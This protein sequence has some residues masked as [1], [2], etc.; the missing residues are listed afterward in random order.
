MFDHAIGAGVHGQLS[1]AAERADVSSGWSASVSRA[2]ESSGSVLPGSVRGT[3]ERSLGVDLSG[4]R[5]HTGDASARAA[6]AVSAKAYAVG[7]DIHFGSG[8][9]DPSSSSGKHLL[10]HEVA[11]TV[12][13]RGASPG[14][15]FKLEISTPGDA[16]EVEADRAADA[17]VRGAPASVRSAGTQL[18]RVVMRTP[19]SDLGHAADRGEIVER[20]ALVAAPPAIAGVTNVRDVAQAQRLYEEIDHD[21]PLLEQG[22][23]TG[24]DGVSDLVGAPNSL[25]TR[26]QITATERTRTALSTF[27]ASAGEQARELGDFQRQYQQCIIDFARIH[28]MMEQFQATH[29]EVGGAT[30]TT[31]ASVMGDS[32]VRAAGGRSVSEAA[33]RTRSI[34]SSRGGAAFG[35]SWNDFRA[36]RTEL[37]TVSREVTTCER[38]ASAQSHAVISAIDS[39]QAGPTTHEAGAAASGELAHVRAECERV[40]TWVRFATTAAASR[41]S[42]ALTAAEAPAAVTSA[43]GHAGAVSDFLVGAAYAQQIQTL[44]TAVARA[45]ARSDSHARDALMRSVR[46]A[47]ET[48]HANLLLLINAMD[49]L[50][51]ARNELRTSTDMTS[52]AADSSGHADTAVIIRFTG[53]CDVFLAQARTAIGLGEAEQA[54]AAYATTDR[55]AAG[56]LVYYGAVM[57]YSRGEITYQAQERHVL[58]AQ[59]Y[60]SGSTEGAHGV[61]PVVAASLTELRRFEGLVRAFHGRLAAAAG[62]GDTAAVSGGGPTPDPGMRSATGEP[63]VPAH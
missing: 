53:E 54:A 21:L 7:Q 39:L 12:Q 26:A 55:T 57:T 17:M 42:T 34:P 4:V 8:Q 31:G 62:L 18:G 47:M 49:R 24:N 35:A 56:E 9:Y 52:R 44:E 19:S 1:R 15:Q 13:Q 5:V 16:C 38:Q 30:T 10:A 58:I 23:R 25:V 43:L 45:G 46:S 61:N 50:H 28:S 3:F 20:E 11:H 37:D 48:W 36:R 27:L 59:D 40:K 22:N 60:T 6:G 41:A 32:V 2:S 33:D 29:P 63:A 14:A 51:A